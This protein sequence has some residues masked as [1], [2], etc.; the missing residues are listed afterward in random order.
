[1][2]QGWQK[3]AVDGDRKWVLDIWERKAER[4]PGIHIG[5]R[6]WRSSRGTTPNSKEGDLSPIHHF[7]KQ[8]FGNFR[9]LVWMAV[10]SLMVQKRGQ[11]RFTL[12]HSSL[13]QP[14]LRL[15]GKHFPYHSFNLSS[16]TPLSPPLNSTSVFQTSKP[17]A[18]MGELKE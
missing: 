2:C 4:S 15:R 11:P 5:R 12:T 9:D 17:F 18:G 10:L 1:M 16:Y 13:A 6:S 3:E 7:Q 8:P 14:C